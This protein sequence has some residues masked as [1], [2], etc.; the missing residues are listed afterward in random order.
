MDNHTERLATGV[1]RIE[2]GFAV[3]TYLL[4]NNGTD[5]AEGL[6]L[7]DTGRA[8]HGAKVVRS[9]RLL[10]FDPRALTD[11]LLTHWH[12]NHAGAAARFAASSAEPRVWIGKGDAD[13]LRGDRPSTRRLRQAPALLTTVEPLEDGRTFPA[14]GGVH[15]VATGGHTPGHCA[16]WLPARGVLL[17]G[18]LLVNMLRLG[19][20]PRRLD[21][22]PSARPAALERLAA[23]E[24][25]V[26]GVGHGPP[27]FDA[28]RALHRFTTP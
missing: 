12:P 4:A 25:A 22:D 20:P 1:W 8:G 6:T 7:V 16:L 27:V 26:I 3:N 11:V 21:A 2:P 18:D 24:P 23:C 19:A 10:G 17:A 5:D 15:V 14:A 28:T 9:I 13:V